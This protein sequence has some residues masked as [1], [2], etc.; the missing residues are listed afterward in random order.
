[1]SQF[2][3][4]PRN[5]GCGFAIGSLIRRAVVVPGAVMVVA[6][7]GLGVI[8]AAPAASAA[9]TSTC[10]VADTNTGQRYTSLQAAVT[11][12]AAGDTLV[13]RGIC[14][15]TTDISKNLTITG[16]RAWIDGHHLTP[17]LNGGGQGSVL[18]I[19]QSPIAVT[20]NTL[21][22]TGGGSGFEG[23]GINNLYGG[24]LTINGS[25][26]TGNATG[27]PGAYGGGIAT[28]GTL[29]INDSTISHN[30]AA[31]GAGIY[32]QAGTVTLNDTS[33]RKNTTSGVGGGIWNQAGTVTMQG[34]SSITGNTASASGGGVCN[35]ATLIGAVDGGNV[36]SNTP[37]NISAT[38]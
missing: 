8:A 2:D 31:N 35:Q 12:A 11:A 9:T 21:K 17:T 10:R 6:G 18:A 26:I 22:I 29:V 37:D 34:S 24:T 20:L 19:A 38:C 14:T 15:G 25:N 13:V 33:V 5:D 32:N 28:E 16:H 1:M 3:Q 23:S 4:Y 27:G 30:T 36:N 7:A